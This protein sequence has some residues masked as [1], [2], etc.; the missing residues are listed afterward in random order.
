M[1]TSEDTLIDVQCHL[2]YIPR[3]GEL[4]NGQW[5]EWCIARGFNRYPG[6]EEKAQGE[7]RAWCHHLGVSL[8]KSHAYILASPWG[9]ML[10]LLT[11]DEYQ[12]LRKQEETIHA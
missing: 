8:M 10:A 3:P 12:D 4:P 2:E 11:E 7:G 9:H 5:R 1:S 6:D